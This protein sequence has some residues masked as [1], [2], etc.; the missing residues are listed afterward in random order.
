MTR[1]GQGRYMADVPK[2]LPPNCPYCDD[3]GAT[4]AY[5]AQDGDVMTRWCV[6]CRQVS[7]VVLPCGHYPELEAS[8]IRLSRGESAY[9]MTCLAWVE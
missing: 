3:G 7:A 8:R 1:N 6:R 5:E 4:C 2:Q 9:C